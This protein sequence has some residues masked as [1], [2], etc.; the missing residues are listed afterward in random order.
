VLSGG[1]VPKVLGL[2]DCLREWVDHRREVLLR[3]SRHR[4]AQIERRL[5]ILRGLLI[6][7]LDLDR[8]I[9]IIREKDEPK[10]S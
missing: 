6:I 7:Y 10:R 9:K 1:K 4:M 8:V 2:V 5:E 3:R